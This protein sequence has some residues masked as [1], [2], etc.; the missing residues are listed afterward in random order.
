MGMDAIRESYVRWALGD[1]G[2][3][4]PWGDVTVEPRGADHTEVS[5]DGLLTAAIG[6]SHDVRGVRGAEARP[7]RLP[8]HGWT[9]GA[10]PPGVV[11]LWDTAWAEFIPFLDY[12]MEIRLSGAWE[13]L[14]LG[15]WIATGINSHL[16]APVRVTWSGSGDVVVDRS[17]HIAQVIVQ[18]VIATR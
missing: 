2:E 16:G 12:D 5:A 14:K 6:L 11:R 3:V 7:G 13:P 10:A 15:T 1:M 9:R 18:L 4:N 17:S 8:G